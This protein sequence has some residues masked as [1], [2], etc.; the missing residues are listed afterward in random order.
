MGKTMQP[1][2]IIRIVPPRTAALGYALILALVS[3][4]LVEAD[5]E[6]VD[7]AALRADARETFKK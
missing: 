2:R 4:C 5:G 3:P 7:E 6:G 1:P